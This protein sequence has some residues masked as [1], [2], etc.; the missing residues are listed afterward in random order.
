MTA[1]LPLHAFRQGLLPPSCR[2]CA[3]W[4]TAGAELLPPEAAAKRKRAW[5]R[6]LES[7]WGTT[8]L[9]VTDP[10]HVLGSIS[11][12]PSGALSRLRDLPFGVL[13][14]ESTLV[15]CLWTEIGTGKLL[16]RRLVHRAMH[17]L[18]HRGASEVF[19][20]AAI[21]TDTAG[22]AHTELGTCRF[23][24]PRLLASCG[25]NVVAEK[26]GL[27]LMQSQLHS[28]LFLLPQLEEA[29]RRVLRRIPSA[30]SPAAWIRQ[31]L[32]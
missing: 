22:D 10:P 20:I 6:Q 17:E 13:P 5:M 1:F 3:W 31:G 32:R 30:P 21:D 9:L 15:F 26:N 24:S 4:H 29:L 7:T 19:A 8:G 27:L 25:F 14:E 28:L 2:E 18:R 12:C 23:F 11:F 16:A